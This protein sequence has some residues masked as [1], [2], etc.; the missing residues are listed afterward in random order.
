[1]SS[2][3]G[4]RSVCRG[5]HAGVGVSFCPGLG[6]GQVDVQMEPIW[7]PRPSFGLLR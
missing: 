2:G 6:I 1:M 7:E 4:T 5:Q 3:K